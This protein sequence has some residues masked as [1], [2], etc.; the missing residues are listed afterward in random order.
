MRERER[1]TAKERLRYVGVFLGRKGWVGRSGHG[2]RVC[3]VDI[4]YIRVCI[5]V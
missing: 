1:E 4:V 3:C 2:G 5:Y